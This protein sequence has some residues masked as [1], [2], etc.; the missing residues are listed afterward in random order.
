MITGASRGI[1]AACKKRFESSYEVISIARTGDMTEN[2]DL[3]CLEF[4]TAIIEKYED[5]D[6]L[7]NNAGILNENALMT[8]DLN[9]I[10]ACHLMEAYAKRGTQI[11]NMGSA[12]G[13]WSASTSISD[14]Q[15]YYSVS[16]SALKKFAEFMS[17]KYKGK[18]TTL[19]PGRVGGTAMGK[20]SKLDAG[21]IAELI[22]WILE[23]PIIIESIHFKGE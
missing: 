13:Y 18:I 7:I 8:Y 11:I 17:A 19:E 10:A 16:K 14:E 4:R 2:G 3:T 22:E 23:Q 1:G 9:Q 21:Y 6:V 12:A 5:I 15:L 20:N